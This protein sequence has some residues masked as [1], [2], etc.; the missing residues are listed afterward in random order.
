MIAK[1]HSCERSDHFVKRSRYLE[2]LGHQ[3]RKW[4]GP[5][6]FLLPS[7]ANKR[8]TGSL[9]QPMRFLQF[10]YLYLFVSFLETIQMSEVE[11]IIYVYDIDRNPHGFSFLLAREKAKQ[12]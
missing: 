3:L 5:P 11:P 12:D 7:L 4:V 6:H 9:Q 2:L 8:H 10:I 1:M